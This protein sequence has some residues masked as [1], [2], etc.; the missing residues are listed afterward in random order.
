MPFSPWLQLFLCRTVR[1]SSHQAPWSIAPR[2][3]SESYRLKRT[4]P[5]LVRCPWQ[6]WAAVPQHRL[7][8]RSQQHKNAGRGLT[9]G[10]EPL[11]LHALFQH[12]GTSRHELPWPDFWRLQV[13]RQEWSQKVEN[14][15]GC[16]YK[17]HGSARSRNDRVQGAA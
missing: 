5:V 6:E 16:P 12:V 4:R 13:H 8:L 9:T 17:R 14:P 11:R 2:Y 3:F 1:P 15:T 10:K 7:Q